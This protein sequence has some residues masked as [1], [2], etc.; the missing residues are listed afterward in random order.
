MLMVNYCMECRRIPKS[1]TELALKLNHV[2]SLNWI[3]EEDCALK[4]ALSM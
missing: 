2:I 3:D 4:E 1:P